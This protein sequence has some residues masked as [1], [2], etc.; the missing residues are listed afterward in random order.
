MSAEHFS[1]FIVGALNSG[2]KKKIKKSRDTAPLKVL[3]DSENVAIIP[4][5][6]S[7]MGIPKK[8][9]N[10]YYMIFMC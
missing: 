3:I 1:L 9:V 4:F 10:S 7:F 5:K 2:K 8:K 6:H